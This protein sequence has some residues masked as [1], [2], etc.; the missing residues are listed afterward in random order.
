M[1]LRDITYQTASV[2]QIVTQFVCILH[3]SVSVKRTVCY[4]ECQGCRLYNVSIA[5]LSDIYAY[6][7][8]PEGKTRSLK[9]LGGLF[10]DMNICC[11][12]STQSRLT[13]TTV[14]WPS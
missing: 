3:D 12:S 11:G 8:V 10:E 2:A 1:K 9:Y 14:L 7:C 5:V 4:P 13:M 6:F